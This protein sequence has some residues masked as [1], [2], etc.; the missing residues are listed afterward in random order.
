MKTILLALKRNK[1][2]T[3]LAAFLLVAVILSAATNYLVANQ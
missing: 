1:L 2:M 3:A